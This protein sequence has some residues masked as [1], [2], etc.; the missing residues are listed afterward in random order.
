MSFSGTYVE[1]KMID[2]LGVEVSV[3]PHLQQRKDV[4]PILGI[5]L[6]RG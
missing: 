2:G 4:A 5:F 6:M 1:T 3:V